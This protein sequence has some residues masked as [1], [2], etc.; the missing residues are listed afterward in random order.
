MDGLLIRPAVEDDAPALAAVHVRAWQW[1]YRGQ[2]PDA[3]LD[4]L[5]RQTAQ[6]EAMWR[7]IA[8]RSAGWPVRVAERDGRVL[9]FCHT[10]PDRGGG[11]PETAELLSIYLEPDAVGTGVGAA[12]LRDALE[13][14]RARGYREAVLWVLESNERARRF[15]ERFGWRADGG[16]KSEEIWGTTAHEVRYR[17]TLTAQEARLPLLKA[18]ALRRG[19]TIGIVAPSWCG[20]AVHPHRVEQGVRFL[21]AQGFRVRLGA[22]ATGQ[23][24]YVSGTPEERAAD[25]HGFFADPEVRAIVAAIGGDHSCHLLPL[26][27]WELIRR[28]PTI[29]VGYSDVTVLNLAIHA[30]TGLVTFNGPALMTDFGEHPEPSAYTIESFLHTVT[31]AEPIGV[32]S[33]SPTWTE[34]SLDWREKLDLTRP[35]AYLP[36]PGWSWLKPGHAEGALVGGCLESMQHLRGTPYWPRMDGAILFFETAEGVP[37]PADV[38]A[39]LQD[40]ENM[41]VLGRIAGLLV[42]RPYRYSDAQRAELHAVLLERTARYAFPIVADLDFGHTSPQLTLPIGCRARIDADERRLAILESAVT[43]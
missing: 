29:L 12:L 40:Y 39:I 14:M 6:R 35:R 20:P 18:P 10:A 15:Y 36:S 25:L 19:D 3:Y 42:G 38:D 5:P 23:R 9:G 41:G 11:A 1:A 16:E 33:P 13:D 27:D 32:L 21:E 31:R 8:G 26:L 28:S 7:G 17:I 24:G 30:M 37:P 43:A 4:D 22:N 2:L 34:E